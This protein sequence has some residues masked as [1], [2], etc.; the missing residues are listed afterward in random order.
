MDLTKENALES[1]DDNFILPKLNSLVSKEP[2]HRII[3]IKPQDKNLELRFI[4][5][6]ALEEVVT[7]AK[8]VIRKF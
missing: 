3:N 8:Q 5:I 1:N 2:T 7:K 6:K 4:V